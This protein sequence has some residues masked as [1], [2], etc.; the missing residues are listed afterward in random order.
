VVKGGQRWLRV[1]KGSRVVNGGQGWST[2][3]NGGQG[4]S[5][6]VN[7]AN[8]RAGQLGETGPPRPFYAAQSEIISAL[9]D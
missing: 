9:M 3:V 1:V 6:V 7:G 8:H 5:T 2:V 4:W